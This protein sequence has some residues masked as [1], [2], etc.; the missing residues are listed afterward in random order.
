MA[1]PCVILSMLKRPPPAAVNTVL[2]RSYELVTSGLGG[3]SNSI[4]SLNSSL[5]VSSIVPPRK[6]A[7]LPRFQLCCCCCSAATLAHLAMA[8]TPVPSV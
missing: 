8:L 6:Q 1:F 2:Y 4:R 7:L 5:C 3:F